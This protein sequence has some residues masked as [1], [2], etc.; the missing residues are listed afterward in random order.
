MLLF[1][2][3]HTNWYLCSTATD[4]PPP[5]LAV[6]PLTDLAAFDNHVIRFTFVN[7]NL[8]GKQ[9]RTLVKSIKLKRNFVY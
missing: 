5:T 4:A 3:L 6:E 2:A 7:C 1:I 9:N 8:D